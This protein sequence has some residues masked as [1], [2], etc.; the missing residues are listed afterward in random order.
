MAKPIPERA[1]RVIEEVVGQYPEGV[2]ARQIGDALAPVPALRTLQYHLKSL[3]DAHRIVMVGRG[4]SARYVLPSEVS[5]SVSVTAGRPTARVRVEVI[6]Q[7]SEAG[8][9]IQGYV[10]APL[11]A[12]SPVGYNRAFLDDYVPNGTAYLSVTER[13]E[14]WRIGTPEVTTEPA[15][16]YARRVLDRLLID[17]SWN[18][19]RLEGNTYSLLDTQRLI[20]E[21][22]TAEGKRAG[23]A[24]MILNH[25]EA[26]QFLVDGAGEV[27]F[28][29]HTVTNLHGLL[30][31]NLLADPEAVGRVRRMVVG[32][33]GTV[34]H[35]L[36]IPQ[37]IEEC[38]DQLLSKDL[39]HPGSIR[40]GILRDGAASL[41]AAVR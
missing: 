40:T 39:G 21:G 33:E 2:T 4:R 27:G 29:S 1:L 19:S 37:L 9:E 28:N 32:I 12:R 6:P 26:I 11:E 38:F 20:E 24:Q 18:S 7:L 22:E 3:I 35:P 41:F 30:A 15:G 23:E 14:L 36:G 25:K 10:T 17:L 5:V 8:A 16:T 34:F 31:D 13:D